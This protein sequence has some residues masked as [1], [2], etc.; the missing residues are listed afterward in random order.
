MDSPQ[1][2]PFKCCSAIT[3]VVLP[4]CLHLACPDSNVFLNSLPS[5]TR[6]CLESKERFGWIAIQEIPSCQVGKSPQNNKRADYLTC[7]LSQTGRLF[8]SKEL[9]F[10]QS[11]KLIF[12]SG[13]FPFW[14]KRQKV[15]ST[16]PHVPTTTHFTAAQSHQKNRGLRCE[17]WT[18]CSDLFWPKNLLMTIQCWQGLGTINLV[19]LCRL[20][21][22]DLNSIRVQTW[23]PVDFGGISATQFCAKTKLAESENEKWLNSFIENRPWPWLHE[24]LDL[25]S[26]FDIIT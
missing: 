11:A 13:S 3:R 23:N 4:V 18:G 19:L 12:F 9:S 8:T 16:Q 15:L 10:W 2:H 6:P 5:A 22:P 1:S 20:R 21:L 26:A 7:I 25:S 17:V 24:T 14:S